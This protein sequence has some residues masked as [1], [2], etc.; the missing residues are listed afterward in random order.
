MNP[1]Q[2]LEVSP[3]ASAEDIKASYHR[4]AKQWHPDRYMGEEKAEAEERFRELAEATRKHASA[5]AEEK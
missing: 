2:V 3:G 4:L 1:F 5:A